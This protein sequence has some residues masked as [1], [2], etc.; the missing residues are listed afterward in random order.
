MKEFK[1]LEIG[2]M[3][4]EFESEMCLI[5]FGETAPP[6]LRA[7]SV[8]HDYPLSDGAETILRPGTKLELGNT[9]YTLTEVGSQANQTFQELG[10]IAIYFKPGDMD[11]LPGSVFAA[12][13]IFP[14][15][16]PGDL[17]RVITP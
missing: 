10:H 5:L 13:A 14:H 7:I 12:P 11:L 6:E 2:E 3:V 17:I 16:A 15:L 1:V 4:P 9:S 8:I